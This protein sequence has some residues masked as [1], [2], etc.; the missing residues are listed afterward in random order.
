[1]R[2]LNARQ[3][4]NFTAKV[5]TLCSEFLQALNVIDIPQPSDSG[6]MQHHYSGD[7]RDP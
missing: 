2:L 3:W 7:R 4:T 6:R 1:M 5:E